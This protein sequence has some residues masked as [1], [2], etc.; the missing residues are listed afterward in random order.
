LLGHDLDEHFLEIL[1]ELEGGVAE[2]VGVSLPLPLV[3]LAEAFLFED[4]HE[5]FD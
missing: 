4:V 2:L 5:L 1:V 3:V